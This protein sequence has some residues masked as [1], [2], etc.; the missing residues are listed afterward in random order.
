MLLLQRRQL[1]VASSGRSSLPGRAVI[2]RRAPARLLRDRARPGT[3]E[4]PAPRETARS[5]TQGR[6]AGRGACAAGIGTLSRVGRTRERGDAPTC[7]PRV[8]RGGLRACLAAYRRHRPRRLQEIGLVDAMPRE[9]RGHCRLPPFRNRVVRRRPTQQRPQ[10]GLGAG[11]QAVADLAVG[12][13]PSAIA[14]A[15]ERPSHRTD[16]PD[17]AWAAVDEPPFGWG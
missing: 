15:A 4:R 6:R 16:N 2:G 11:E 3:T 10:I 8:R 7:S 17:G 9:L 1:V 5:P 12:G 14:G 13:Q